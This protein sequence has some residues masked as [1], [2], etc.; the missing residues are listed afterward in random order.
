MHFV[1][2][3]GGAGDYNV[4]EL[5]CRLL[6]FSGKWRGVGVP[7]GRVFDGLLGLF[8][9]FGAFW[10]RG[11]LARMLFL[12]SDVFVHFLFLFDSFD[13]FGVH[14]E[15]DVD[16]LVVADVGLGCFFPD[17]LVDFV[18]GVLFEVVVDDDVLEGVRE[19]G[20]GEPDATGGS[21]FGDEGVL[22]VLLFARGFVDTVHWAGA[23]LVLGGVV[24]PESPWHR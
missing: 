24:Q 10:V 13:G 14:F 11:V 8:V 18:V 21:R 2:G 4:V 22:A 1:C 7:P 17:V 3:V 15:F 23:V 19:V 12:D 5:R 20:L 16:L 9:L 6:D